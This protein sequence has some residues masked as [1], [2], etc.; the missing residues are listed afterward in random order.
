MKS[1]LLTYSFRKTPNALIFLIESAVYFF[2]PHKLLKLTN[3]EIN[4]LG[5]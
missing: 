5:R 1:T 4:F 3:D 2:H